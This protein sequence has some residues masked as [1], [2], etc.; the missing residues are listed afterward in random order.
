MSTWLQ[1]LEKKDPK[2]AEAYKVVGNQSREDLK[3]MVKALSFCSVF[4]TE[5]DNKRLAAA[6]LILRR[7]K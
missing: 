3:C 4:N 5:E 2:L 7:K 6:K 1:D